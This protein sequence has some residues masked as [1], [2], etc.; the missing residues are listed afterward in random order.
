MIARTAAIVKS[1]L[2]E[3]GIRVLSY[4]ELDAAQYRKD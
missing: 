1:V 3:R 2:R 4:G